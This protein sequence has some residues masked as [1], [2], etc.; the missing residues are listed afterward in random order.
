MCAHPLVP[1]HKTN[2]S[3]KVECDYFCQVLDRICKLC[4]FHMKLNLTVSLFV[5]H[6]TTSSNRK[7]RDGQAMNGF[8]LNVEANDC[9]FFR[10]MYKMDM[11]LKTIWIVSNDTL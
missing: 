9:F 1:Q 7:C 11:Y 5:E 4:K 3:Q 6:I 10:N 2:F 8:Y